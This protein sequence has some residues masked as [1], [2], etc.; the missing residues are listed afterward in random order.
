MIKTCCLLY[1]VCISLMS[2]AQKSDA[3]YGIVLTQIDRGDKEADTTRFLYCRNIA[4]DRLSA[5]TIRNGVVAEA[6]AY[7][8]VRSKNGLMLF[9]TPFPDGHQAKDSIRIIFRDKTHTVVI[10]QTDRYILFPAY[11]TRFKQEVKVK[12]SVMALLILLSDAL[13]DYSI[14]AALPLVNF[15]PALEKHI[16]QAR[17]VT[18]RSQADMKDNWNCKYF[19][20]KR[21]QLDSVNARS[22]EEVRF[23]KKIHYHFNKAFMISTCLNIEDRQVTDRTISYGNLDLSPV[24]WQQTYE[25]PGKN[26]ETRSSA[27]LTWHDLGM[28]R[29]LEPSNQEVLKMLKPIKTHDYTK[30]HID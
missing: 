27:T 19:Y 14:T 16:Q 24:K 8:L 29:K 2:F 12:H 9:S 3:Y 21:N 17:I 15:K 30:E 4:D 18:Q 10:N 28:L 7:H 23:S 13:G 11:Y 6:T 26:R 20:N 5:Y 25:E 22:S 1:L